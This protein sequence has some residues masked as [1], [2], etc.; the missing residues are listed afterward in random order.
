MRA[1]RSIAALLLT[2][3][4]V[5]LLLGAVAG[6]LIG[7]HRDPTGSFTA[8]LAPVHS[9]GYAIVVPDLVGL[10][11]RHGVARWL[12]PGDLRVT[13]RSSD[14]LVLA[15]APA[16]EASRYLDG[17][18]RTEVTG[19]GYA[20][21]AQPVSVGTVGGTDVPG[22]LP[23][24]WA[25]AMDGRAVEWSMDTDGPVSLVVFRADG[26]PGLTA[27][28]T[29]GLRPSSWGVLAG[30]LLFGGAAVVL[31]GAAFLVLPGPRREVVLVV[32]RDRVVDV[33]DRIAGHMGTDWIPRRNRRRRRAP[34]LDDLYADRRAGEANDGSDPLSR[35]EA[36]A[37]YVHTA[38]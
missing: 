38:T 32:E 16:V 12:G 17:V 1:L 2:A 8:E 25:L 20:S 5:V 10:A 15:L 7:Q 21:G 35:A 30:G 6:W 37:S 18:A 23:S 11:Q 31:A 36:G 24:S 13:A 26:R 28:L 34:V 9:D 19:I 4:G 29:A 27:T 22:T 3:V 14:R 33:A